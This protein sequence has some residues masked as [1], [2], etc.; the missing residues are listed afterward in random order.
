[1]WELSSRCRSLYGVGVSA[2][3]DLVLLLAPLELWVGAV[4]LWSFWQLG[5]KWVSC[6]AAPLEVHHSLMDGVGSHEGWFG[7]C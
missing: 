6:R 3:L 4:V 7:V 1:M 2:P 5:W